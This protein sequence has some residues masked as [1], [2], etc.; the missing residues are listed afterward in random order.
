MLSTYVL[1]K[2]ALCVK[3]GM[4][5]AVF[6]HFCGGEDHEAVWLQRGHGTGQEWTR[7]RHCPQCGKDQQAGRQDHQ[8]WWVSLRRSM[9]L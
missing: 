1:S 2:W 3:R 9:I 5:V 6:Q 4:V 8:C 7:N